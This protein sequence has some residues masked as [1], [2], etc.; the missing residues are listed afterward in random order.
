METKE[1]TLTISER[2]AAIKLFDAFKGSV[3]QLT[4][5][6]DDIKAFIISK[7]EW[8]AANLTKTPGVDEEGKAVETWNWNDEGNEKVVTMGSESAQYLFNAIKAK[9]DASELTIA[10]KALVS[11]LQKLS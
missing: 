7:E 1:L 6:F 10:D 8:E 2:V 5:I 9:S 4:Q 11:L 3:S